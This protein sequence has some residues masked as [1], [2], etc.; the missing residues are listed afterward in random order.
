MTDNKIQY[1]YQILLL[2]QQG[3][4][5]SERRAKSLDISERYFF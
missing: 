3:L 2:H 4:M 5:G 1:R